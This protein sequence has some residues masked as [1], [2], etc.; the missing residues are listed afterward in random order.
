MKEKHLLVVFLIVFCSSCVSVNIKSGQTKKADDVS[1]R[2][3]PAPFEDTQTELA[4]RS[5][6]NPRN[7][8]TISFQSIC[9]EAA[10]P[11]LV[12]IRANHIAGIQNPIVDS[13]ERKS[14]NSRAALFTKVSG[15]VDGV[16]VMLD[17]VIFKKNNCS[18]TLTYLGLK[19]KFQD[20]HKAFLKFLDGFKAP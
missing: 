12:T 13:E 10:D 1:L 19:S 16:P 4:D 17:L 15:Q 6:R 9:E 5:W 2:E 3:P 18:Y 8:N 11:T 20:N 14:Y 7:G